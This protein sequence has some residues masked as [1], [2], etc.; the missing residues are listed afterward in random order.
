MDR[1]AD[2]RNADDENDMEIARLIRECSMTRLIFL[3]LALTAMSD[4]ALAQNRGCDYRPD[5][6]PGCAPCR[7]PC[8]QQPCPPCE[9]KLAVP[10]GVYA[11]PPAVGEMIGESRA[12][13]LRGLAI[14]IPE[15][16]F[17]LPTIRLP[18]FIRYR[19]GP[20]M[21]VGP[22]RAPYVSGQAATFGMMAPGG[23]ALPGELPLLQLRAP[24]KTD[25]PAEPTRRQQPCSPNTGRRTEESFMPP[26]APPAEELQSLQEELRR[27][28]A[29]ISQLQ[30]TICHA[31]ES[32][33]NT[34]L[35]RQRQSQLLELSRRA[36]RSPATTNG[37]H[38][39]PAAARQ[40]N[41]L[42]QFMEGEIRN[43]DYVRTPTEPPLAPPT[44][45]DDVS[46]AGVA[47]QSAHSRQAGQTDSIEHPPETAIVVQPR[48]LSQ[49]GLPL[50]R[51]SAQQ[52]SARGAGRTDFQRPAENAGLGEH[53]RRLTG[54]LPWAD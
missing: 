38:R 1:A 53:I 12:L 23:Q 9:K 42:R 35:E 5:C 20:E 25:E 14:E 54:S 29:V 41:G 37:D 3:L 43:T 22:A 19:R 52:D 39:G 32:L 46:T 31:R 21:H 18:N 48:E 47:Q 49:R 34:L 27:Q 26:P 28:Q 30:E 40:P 6:R 51:P 11:Q 15:I 45:A 16:H 17:E 36:N 4:A 13:G 7:R 50:V 2:D 8:R 33:E 44:F 10:Q 24:R